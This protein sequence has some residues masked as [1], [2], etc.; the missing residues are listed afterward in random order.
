MAN[1]KYDTIIVGAGIAG[2]TAAVYLARSGQKILLIEKNKECGGLVNTFP[3]DGFRFEAGVRALENAGI[4]FPMLEDL[5]IE[6]EV[7]RSKVSLGVGDEIIHIEDINSLE[8]YRQLL[9]KL[10]PESKSDI[11][12]LLKIIRKIMKHM[13]VLYDVEN[14]AFKDLKRDKQYIFKQLLPW[15][16]KFIFTVGKINRMNMPVEDYL[17]GIIKDSSLR[18]IVAQHFFKA[19]PTFF[20]P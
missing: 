13:E 9:T 15:L 10:Y 16:P 1:S 12:D 2:L 8:D 6:M 17:E 18:D 5:G 11:D 19:T 14:P 3:R 7:V 4:I 20:L